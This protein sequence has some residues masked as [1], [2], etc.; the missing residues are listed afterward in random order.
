MFAYLSEGV[1]GLGHYRDLYPLYLADLRYVACQR[2]IVVSKEGGYAL[3][4][5]DGADDEMIDS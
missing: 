3:A 4:S 2:G 5:S 1:H